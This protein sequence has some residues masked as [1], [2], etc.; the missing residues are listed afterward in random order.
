VIVAIPARNEG[1][2]VGDVLRRHANLLY[3][4]ERYTVVAN[5]HSADDTVDRATRV[6]DEEDLEGKVVETPDRPVGWVGKMWALKSAL[7]AARQERPEADY[8]LFCDADIAIDPGMLRTLVT[9][10]EAEDLDMA[11]IMARLDTTG[12]WARLLIPAFVFFFQKL[13]PF[14]D[15]NDRAR[16]TAAAAGGCMLVRLSA[17]D[18]AG[19]LDAVKGDI[20]DDCALARAI[21]RR[22]DGPPFRPIWLGLSRSVRSLRRYEGLPDIWAMVIRSAFEQLDR[23][24]WKAGLTAAAMILVYAMPVVSLIYG[25]TGGGWWPFLFGLAALLLMVRAY[26]PTLIF[27]DRPWWEA[28]LLP[29][30]A[31]FYL[32]MTLDSAVKH[33]QGRGGQWKGR[34]GAG[35]DSGESEG[36]RA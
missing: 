11:S 19:G 9:K 7:D 28:F 1:D 4:G 24:S 2:V 27:Y 33:I 5:D 36:A 20:I 15:V 16:S 18:E 29:V 3:P 32:G 25:L 13:Y 12:F 6:F 17:L 21:K 35:R 31:M 23:K 10:A 34:P 14:S 26:R 8:V 30:A 22:V